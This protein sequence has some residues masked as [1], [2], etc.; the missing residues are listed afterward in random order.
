MSD[1]SHHA[2]FSALTRQADVSCALTY[3]NMAL[4]GTQMGFWFGEQT[5]GSTGL[6]TVAHYVEINATLD[7][8]ALPASIRQG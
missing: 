6:Y 1:H 7:V 5:A 2:H 8:A 3:K 4:N